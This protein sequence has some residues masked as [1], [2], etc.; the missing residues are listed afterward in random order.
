MSS[1]TSTTYSQST[2]LLSLVELPSK[3]KCCRPRQWPL[4][5]Y[6]NCKQ[7]L[8]RR[9]HTRTWRNILHI[10]LLIWHWT[11]NNKPLPAAAPFWILT[12]CVRV[13]LG[14]SDHCMRTICKP[15]L[16][17]IGLEIAEVHMF[18]YFQDDRRPPILECKLSLLM[19]FWSVQM[20][21]GYCDFTTLRIWLENA[22]SRQF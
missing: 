20:R 6:N 14:T 17:Q 12:Y 19:A 11:S 18:M 8:T 16:V 5:V 15:N 13:I 2:T 22:Y 9:L 4:C 7:E 10:C 21:L 3:S 1:R